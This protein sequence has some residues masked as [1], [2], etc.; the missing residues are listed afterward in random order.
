MKTKIIN[1]F[2]GPNSG[3]STIASG[4][5]YNLKIRDINSELISE[6]AKIKVW[7]DNKKTLKNQIYL[8]AKQH[9][10]INNVLGLVDFIIIDSPLLLN[11]IYDINKC[12]IFEK[13]CLIEHNKLNNINF[14]L[15]RENKNFENSG[16]IHSLEESLNIDKEIK[17]N[18]NKWG[19]NFTEIVDVNDIID[20]LGKNGYI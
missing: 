4:L 18:L 17:I 15:N 19:I 7:E 11:P 13:L 16:R 14:F 20:F 2:G 12:N 10:A 8:F 5:F 3:K 9:F 6:Y 1:L